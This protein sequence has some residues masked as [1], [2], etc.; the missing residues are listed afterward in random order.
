MAYRR[1]GRHPDRV[2]YRAHHNRIQLQ[3]PNHDHHNEL[4]DH[5]DH[6]TAHHDDGA[7]G[8]DDHRRAHHDNCASNDDDNGPAHDHNHDH[9]HDDHPIAGTQDRHYEQMAVGRVR[10]GSGF[11]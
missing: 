11:C 3:E 4:V 2:D 1:T 10:L 8:H 9:D 6:T 7:P 5:D